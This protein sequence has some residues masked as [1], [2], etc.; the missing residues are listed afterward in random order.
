MSQTQQGLGGRLSLL[1]PD[2]LS[3]A[4]RKTYDTIKTKMV[5]WAEKS[6]FKAKNDD[7]T[8]IGPFQ[9]HPAQHGN[10]GAVRARGG[11]AKGRAAKCDHPIARG[12]D[13]GDRAEG[14]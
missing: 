2:A 8:L 12:G 7:G 1:E 4:Q 5:P 10:H 14:G 6:G 3:P 11:G 9:R 13:A